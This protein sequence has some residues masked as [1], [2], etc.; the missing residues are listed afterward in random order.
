MKKAIKIAGLSLLALIVLMVDLAVFANSR[1]HTPVPMAPV[2]AAAPV[3]S[4]DAT[5]LTD[6]INQ[7]RIRIGSPVLITEH[8]LVSSATNKLNDEVSNKYYGHNLLDGSSWSTFARTQGVKAVASEDLDENALNPTDDWS[9]FKNSPAHYASLTDPQYSRIG[10]AE[11]C[12]DFTLQTGTGPGDNS[13]LV[14]TSIKE[15]TVIHLAGPEPVVQSNYGGTR[16][17]DG[18]IS[19]STGSG[20]CSWHGGEL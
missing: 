16:C 19:S 1:P 4:P 6:L 7:E 5:K 9:A 2:A 11:Q 14:G 18:S 13:S 15:L 12:T 10:V 20:T 3:C 17:A 8:S